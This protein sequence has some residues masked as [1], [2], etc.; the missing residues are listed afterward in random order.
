VLSDDLIAT[1]EFLANG[2]Q[3]KPMQA[4]LRRATS[5]AYYALFHTLAQCCADLLIGSSSA[6]RSKPA[7]NQVYRS[8]EHNPARLACQDK[9]TMPKFPKEIQDF[10]NMFVLMQIERHDADYD[11][12]QRFYKSAV[13]TNIA[14]AEIVMKDFGAA[15]VKDRRAFAAWVLFKK[16]K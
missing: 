5:T 15:P 13:L 12:D 8:L 3:G 14:A 16:R 4:Y 9:Q 6:Q 11:P 7:W 2:N 1:A 10:A